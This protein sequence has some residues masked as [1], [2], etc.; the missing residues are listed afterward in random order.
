MDKKKYE[1]YREEIANEQ[2][3]ISTLEA[4]PD[5]ESVATPVPVIDSPNVSNPISDQQQN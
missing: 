1:Q 2:R 3:A 5:I 4:Q